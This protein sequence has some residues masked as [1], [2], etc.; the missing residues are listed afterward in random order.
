GDGKIVLAGTYRTNSDDRLAMV[1]LTSNGRLDKTLDKDG[2]LTAFFPGSTQFGANAVL[3]QPG[4]K[5]VVAGGA[6]VN[7]N[8]QFGLMRFDASG[9]IDPS[10]GN[11][12][13]VE[14]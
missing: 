12:G 4:G 1:R 10:F 7:G 8:G 11:N 14:T 13:S 9:A 2:K 5:I 3:V 6:V